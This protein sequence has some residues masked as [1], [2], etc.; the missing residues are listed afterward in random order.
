MDMEVPLD[1]VDSAEPAVNGIEDLL[2]PGETTVA[3]DDNPITSL[4]G[5]KRP[6]IRERVIHLERLGLPRS[7]LV[8]QANQPV[9]VAGRVRRRARGD[10]PWA[11]PGAGALTARR[12]GSVR[13]FQA[14]APRSQG[15]WQSEG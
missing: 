2:A 1:P 15:R 8:Q 10:H 9:P 14:G 4:A 7:V 3:A 6:L 12:R 13:R 5:V 11:R